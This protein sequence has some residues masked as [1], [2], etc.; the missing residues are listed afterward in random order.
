MTEKEKAVVEKLQAARTRRDFC[1][2][3]T[4]N[5]YAV[6]FGDDS[7]GLPFSALDD[8]IAVNAVHKV[9]PT[10][11]VYR[12]GSYCTVDGKVKSCLPRLCVRKG[13]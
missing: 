3:H 1:D 9:C 12:V 4:V 5:L 11:D 8:D 2:S 13:V 7:F 6:K 10:Q